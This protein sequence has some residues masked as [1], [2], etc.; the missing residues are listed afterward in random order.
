MIRAVTRDSISSR[1]RRTC[2]M[3]LPAGSSSCQSRY[4][5]PGKNGP[6]QRQRTDPG[7]ED[8]LVPIA[9]ALTLA[10]CPSE[11]AG[12]QRDTEEDHHTQDDGSDAEV[13]ARGAQAEPAGQ[14]LEVEPAETGERHCLE[15]AVHGDQ[16]GDGFAVTAGQIVPDQHHGDTAG[17]TYDDQPRSELRKVGK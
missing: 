9:S 13:G 5:L 2:V 15:D 11:E 17:E 14:D 8:R 12:E 3:S 7:Q 1:I 6:V 4:V 16:Y 10:H